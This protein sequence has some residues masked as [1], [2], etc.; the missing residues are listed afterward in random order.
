MEN[1]LSRLI[2]KFYEY[3]F[4]GK[5]AGNENIV[6]YGFY[7]VKNSKNIT[8]KGR[9]NINDYVYINGL[10]GI[11]LGQNVILSAGAMLISTGLEINKSGFTNKHI[12]KKIVINDNVQIGAGAK[13]LAGVIITSNVVIGAGS[14]V[15]KDINEPGVYV[16]SPVKKI[17]SF[18]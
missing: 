18:I 10:G 6:A 16:G 15:T 7:S 17:R 3:I 1:K 11:E 2:L 13:V 5:F 14:V 9:V 4:C 8:L 12:N